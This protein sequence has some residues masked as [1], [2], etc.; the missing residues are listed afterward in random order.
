VIEQDLGSNLDD[1]TRGVGVGGMASSALPSGLER[2]AEQQLEQDDR[3]ATATVSI[4]VDDSNPA[5]A[6]VTMV[7]SIQP[8][9]GT[10]EAIDLHVPIGTSSESAA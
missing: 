2:T 6:I 9:D 10:L 1:P 3:V 5:Q 4:E 7:A 8:S